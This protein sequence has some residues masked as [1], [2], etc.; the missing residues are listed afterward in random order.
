MFIL[1]RMDYLEYKV[2]D[3]TIRCFPDNTFQKWGRVSKNSKMGWVPCNF[4]RADVPTNHYY[5]TV[6]RNNEGIKRKFYRHRMIYKAYH[7]EFDLLDKKLIIDHISHTK[8]GDKIENLRCV[9]QQMNV[10]NRQKP[11][12]GYSRVGG[13]FQARITDDKKR[14]SLGYFLTEQEAAEAYKKAVEEKLKK[15]FNEY[16]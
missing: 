9:T 3:N 1:P 10:W 16:K 4:Y 13:K 14:K 5:W 8:A 11:F 15:L 12:K 6:L 2:Y 7:P